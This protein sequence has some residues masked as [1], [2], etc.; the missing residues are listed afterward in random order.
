MGAPFIGKAADLLARR[1][2]RV[3]SLSILLALLAGVAG[4]ARAQEGS[5][6]SICFWSVDG[7]VLVARPTVRMAASG[8][9]PRELLT[10][11][12]SGPTAQE[13]ARGVWSVLPADAALAGVTVQPDRT[14]VVR[15]DL[16]F[17]WLRTLDHG[18]FERVVD[19]VGY[20]LQPLDW[21]DLHIQ[22]W[23]P[24]AGEFVPLASFLPPIPSPHKSPGGREG[25]EPAPAY[26]GQ[27]PAPGQGQPQGSLSGRTVYVSAGHGWEWENGGWRVQ[28]I[29]YPSPPYVGPIIEDFN[30]AEA[31]NQYLLQYL[32]NAG[33]LVFPVR[34]RDMNGVALVVDN[35]DP[36]PGGYIES[37]AWT[38]TA[39]DGYAS[40]SYR[41]T[42][43]VAG[44]A[45]ATAVWTTTIPA[46]GEYAVY[47]WF[48]F[49]AD[50]A[51]DA[52]YTIHHAGGDTTVIIDQR[53]HGD[54][55][56]YLG[57]YGFL[58]GEEARVELSNESA[59]AGQVVVADAVRIGG[60]TFDSLE[61][62]GTIASYPP[63][64]PWWEV[65][66]FYYTQR[67]GMDQPDNDVVARPVYARW[68]HWGSGEDAVYV[69]WHTN[70]VSGYQED[71]SGTET[72]AH[73][74][75]WLPRTEGSLS[76]RHAVHSEVVRDIRAGWDPAWIDRGEKLKNLGELRLLW[77]DD[78]AMRMPGALIEIAFHDNPDDTDQLKEPSFELLV[79]RAIYQ[80]IVHYFEERDGVDLDLLPEPPTHLAV[81]NV[82]AGMVRVSWH[83]SP[84]DT[85][86]LVGDAAT[87]YRVYTSSNGIGWSN[88]VPV[89]GTTAYTITGLAPE[90]L[91]FVRVTAT[92]DGGESFPT[93]TL[94]ARVGNVAGILLVS[95]FDRLN[96]TMLIPDVYDPTGQSHMR[97]LL[98]QMNSYDYT[99]QH[100]EVISYAF[101]SSSN[102]AVRDGLV[103]LG[104][105]GLV[106]WILGEESAPDETLD[107]TERS[108]VQ[109][110]LEDGGALFISGAEVG[111][112][113]DHLA[114]D[115][116]FYHGSLRASYV[117]DDA[118]TY[119][120]A[121]ASGSIFAGLSA[122]RFDAPGMYDADYPDVIAPAS[123][124]TAALAYQGGTGGTAGVQY[125][126][127]CERLVYLGFP[128]ETV[129]PARRPAVMGRVLDYLDECLAVM[130]NTWIGSPTDCGAYNSVPPFFG[131]AQALGA[132]VDRVEV[133]VRRISDG[134]YWDGSGWVVTE[135]WLTASGTISWSYPLPP[136]S[137]GEYELRARA[138]AG[139]N[140]D[141]SPAQVDLAY[142]TAPPSS[143]TLITPTGGV[144]ITAV[145]NVPLRWSAPPDDGTPL[146]YVVTL[147]GQPY[148]TTR[149]VYTTTR[150][151]AGAHTW[152][153]QVV[154]AAGNHSAWVTATFAVAQHYIW[155]PMLIRGMVDS[156]P[157][158]EDVI[159]NGGFEADDGWVFNRVTLVTD[160]TYV[161]SGARSAQVG[162]L[163]G[164]PGVYAYSSVRQQ[165]TLSPGVT[166]T[167]R[168][169]LY[170]ISE[171]ADPGDLHYISLY[172]QWG[173]FHWID[174]TT[175][176]QR[177]WVEREYDLSPYLG[178]TVKLYIGALNDGDDDTAALYVDDVSLE[179]CH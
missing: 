13:R 32:W 22:V 33:A 156:V 168:L 164:E 120:V 144:T 56:R 98:R 93:E 146:A 94:A 68:E 38:T 17:A 35:D 91:L 149:Q 5:P 10:A 20:T 150:I 28:R 40:T 126:N 114:A 105:Y 51:P 58:G 84:T 157:G 50:R 136:L 7:P 142:D 100:G 123:G 166:A 67:M 87:G 25:M 78:P 46:D 27:P 37:G 138:W 171:G 89:T 132:T 45:T 161:H 83:P 70:G 86:G 63:N 116:A 81:R 147:D 159:V 57:S 44:S 177:Q 34:E 102:E 48:K 55:W 85:I 122:F 62:I 19:Q 39:G 96:S 69:A 148:T 49:G 9:E 115:P 18:S 80:G 42:D 135:T 141:A 92:N 163:P 109:A 103:S 173:G 111:W 118:G 170:P 139:G 74:G 4:P 134:Y 129:W 61:G 137:D 73:N 140:V 169:W 101:D 16:P 121:P 99:I 79:A 131:T 110:F 43:T 95:G 52:H 66:A 106:D 12:L 8:P 145:A 77:D 128:F 88:G 2:T 133:T 11:L 1:M 130:V 160:P 178:Q 29:P 54:T 152:G 154:D 3:L 65:A 14:V 155:F 26:V 47:V 82:G 60:G 125:A 179:V 117:G 31:V 90:Q 108:L 158:C 112:H 41:W 15:F 59:V 119:Q 53:V 104:D 127:G 176:D 175:T 124:S 75:E 153:V 72:Y 162:I 23:D 172:D 21:R 97:M 151:A 167:L 107:A 76:L 30:N 64:E 113:L 71:Y 6:P 143:A 24:I 174:T 36:A 165:V